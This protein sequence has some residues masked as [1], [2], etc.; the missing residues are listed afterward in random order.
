MH[1]NADASSQSAGNPHEGEDP[2][3]ARAA[4]SPPAPAR[5]ERAATLTSRG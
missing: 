5:L 4:V 2:D 3:R 1:L